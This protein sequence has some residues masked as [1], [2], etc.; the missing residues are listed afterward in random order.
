[1]AAIL[2]LPLLLALA[3]MSAVTWQQAKANEA[4]G[5]AKVTQHG[6]FG[7]SPAALTAWVF[8]YTACVAM[9]GVAFILHFPGVGKHY[10]FS[11]EDSALY[12]Y[13][14]DGRCVDDRRGLADG[15][16]APILCNMTRAGNQTFAHEFCQRHPDA[17][18]NLKGKTI[19]AYDYAIANCAGTCGCCGPF[20]PASHFAADATE[21]E[22][23]RTSTCSIR[24]DIPNIG[25]VYTKFD[26]VIETH[27]VTG[28]WIMVLGPL[29]LLSRVRKWR[30]YQFHRYNGRVLLLAVI[31]NQASGLWLAIVGITDDHLG[32]HMYTKV[33]RAGFLLLVVFTVVFAGFG[34]YYIRPQSRD[35]KK[36]GEY[37][38]RLVAC[39]LSVPFFRMLVP[40]ARAF[41]GPHWAFAVAAWLCYPVPL[42]SAEAYIRLA[43]RFVEEADASS[44]APAV[45]CIDDARAQELDATVHGESA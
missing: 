17:C 34:Y 20:D 25:W 31:P 1:M 28:M 43:G 12:T 13:I 42:C 9:A 39:W 8:A 29:Q 36:H 2:S 40:V 22:C 35:V 19:T 10:L 37:M 24:R 27:V 3:G 45:T 41:V 16:C 23:E 14:V 4:P 33:F 11:G 30:Q 32:P 7:A 38:I 6:R 15:Y 26:Y 18:V 5:A 44:P 21:L